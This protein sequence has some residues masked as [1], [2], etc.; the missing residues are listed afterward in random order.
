MPVTPDQPAPEGWVYL[1][2]PKL[3]RSD[4]PVP[5]QALAAWEDAGW[6]AET[7]TAAKAAKKAAAAAVTA[8]SVPAPAPPQGAVSGHPEPQPPG[9]ADTFV[10]PAKKE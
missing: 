2:H 4:N 8:K 6:K 5:R 10:T 3:G 9:G 7:A 1:V